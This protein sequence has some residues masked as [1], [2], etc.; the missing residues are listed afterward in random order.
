VELVHTYFSNKRNS[1]TQGA[2]EAESFWLLLAA[3][4][5]GGSYLLSPGTSPSSAFLSRPTTSS[6]QVGAFL[7]MKKLTSLGS[8]GK[9]IVP[10]LCATAAVNCSVNLATVCGS[11]FCLLPGATFTSGSGASPPL[12]MRVYRAGVSSVITRWRGAAGDDDHAQPAAAAMTS[13]SC[14]QHVLDPAS[15]MALGSGLAS[16]FGSEGG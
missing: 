14:P 10:F 4:L 5:V 3:D 11:D 13:R 6:G 16:A 2:S 15:G 1:S 8:L 9:I 7:Q 12:E